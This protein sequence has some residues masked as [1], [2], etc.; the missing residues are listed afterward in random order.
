MK[1]F[2]QSA[3]TYVA[4]ELQVTRVLA[5]NINVLLLII[6]YII[7]SHDYSDITNDKSEKFGMY[8]LWIFLLDVFPFAIDEFRGLT[9]QSAVSI[10]TLLAETITPEVKRL[11]F[12][13]GLSKLM[14]VITIMVH[15]IRVATICV[16][17]V[18]SDLSGLVSSIT[19]IVFLLSLIRGLMTG[20]G[21]SLSLYHMCQGRIVY[22]HFVSD[23][24]YKLMTSPSSDRTY[25]MKI[26]S[27]PS[28]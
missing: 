22:V 14:M 12:A 7:A 17:F 25:M 2:H 8:I 24:L 28:Y 6:L 19:F 21:I 11:N 23:V 5:I 10:K 20:V 13:Y 18:T 1:S 27:V 15:L 26:K 9:A 16:F 3:A 4:I